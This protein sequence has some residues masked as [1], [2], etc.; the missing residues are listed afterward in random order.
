MEGIVK[1]L[2]VGDAEIGSEADTVADWC[3][4][5]AGLGGQRYP[6]DLVP[7]LKS[8]RTFRAILLGA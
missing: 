8:A 1:L 6:G 7:N 3:L 5:A 2:V 4:F